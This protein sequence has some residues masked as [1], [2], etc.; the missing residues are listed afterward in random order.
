MLNG[1]IPV[2]LT[3]MLEDY[4]I[5]NDG[6]KS[7]MKHL[8]SNGIESIWALGSAS[9]EINIGFHKKIY[10]AKLINHINRQYCMNVIMGTGSISLDD[11]YKFI[12]KTIECE[13]YGLHVLPYDTKMGISRVVNLYHKIADRSPWP[14][15]MYHNPKRGR[16][17]EIETIK[18]ISKHKNIGG[19]KMGGYNLNELTQCF[20]LK[21]VYFVV[22]AEGSG[23]LYQCL[24][25]GASAHTTSEGSV[26]PKL[27]QKVKELYDSGEHDAAFKLQ[28]KWIKLNSGIKRTQNGEH[29]AE[30][31]YLLSLQGI[32]GPAVN[33]NYEVYPIHE[34]FKL[35]QLHAE[36]M[37]ICE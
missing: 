23:Q 11:H 28:S 25:L 9:E 21:Y 18:E 33:E 15:W 31:K 37:L 7:L 35:E 27:F 6:M 10:V 29:C 22:V 5:D 17:F 19:I 20:M 24:C 8:H 3:P 13:F 12:D 36:V 14:V 16:P 30:E 4:S 32:C 34:R 26:Y 1:I 2:L